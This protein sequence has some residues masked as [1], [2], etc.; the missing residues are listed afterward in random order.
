MSGLTMSRTQS[1]SSLATLT[2]QIIVRGRVAP[3]IREA[4]VSGGATLVVH[5][6][7]LRLIWDEAPDDDRA[8][9][10]PSRAVRDDGAEDREKRRAEVL[11]AQ[12]RGL[13]DGGYL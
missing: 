13:D 6:V 3:L 9:E 11:A 12:R 7:H 1:P 4:L 10:L 2:E 8:V 5:G